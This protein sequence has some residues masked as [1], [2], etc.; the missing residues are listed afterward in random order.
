LTVSLTTGFLAPA[1]IVAG[2]FSEAHGR[3]SVMVLSLVAS[4]VLT[5]FA[6]VAPTWTMLLGIRALSGVA[7]AGLPAISMA[8]LS[9]EVSPTSIGLAMGLAIGG[10]GLGGMLGRL[11]VSM[12][13]DAS[14]WRYALFAVGIFGLAATF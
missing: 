6:A 9:E 8:Y 10:N 7:F 3:K 13:T 4:S 14:S 11:A 12:I 2:A 5:L 1:M